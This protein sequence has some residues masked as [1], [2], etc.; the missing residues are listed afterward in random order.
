MARR[1]TLSFPGPFLG[2]NTQAMARNLAPAYCS[3]CDNVVFRD[4]HIETRPGMVEFCGEGDIVD[5]GL[6]SVKYVDDNTD[7]AIA[8]GSE[9]I[10][11]QAY[12]HDFQPGKWTPAILPSGYIP[13]SGAIARRKN[14]SYVATGDGVMAYR[15][16]MDN[17]VV[18]YAGMQPYTELDHDPTMADT[19]SGT[20][21]N[22]TVEFWVSRYNSDAD[23]ESNAVR[24]LTSGDSETLSMSNQEVTISLSNI[25]GLSYRTYATHVR[26]YQRRSDG[27]FGLFAEIPVDESSD[28]FSYS[29]GAAGEQNGG[30]TYS[31]AADDTNNI[32]GPP[33][34]NGVPPQNVQAMVY[35]DGRMFY[36]EGDKLWYS[37]SIDELQ[38]HPES[39][40]A[41]SY[42]TLRDDGVGLLVYRESLY[43]WTKRQVLRMSGFV[44][45]LTNAQVANGTLFDE[46]GFTAFVE[47]VEGVPGCISRDSIVEGDTGS[48][49][50]VFYAGPAN[51]YRFDGVNASPVSDN[52]VQNKH[53]EWVSADGVSSAHYHELNLVVFCYKNQG[54]LAY[55]YIR[56]TWTKWESLLDKYAVT[57]SVI[58]PMSTRSIHGTA[59]NDPYLML[60]NSGNGDLVYGGSVFDFTLYY[61]HGFSIPATWTGPEIDLGERVRRKRFDH[62]DVEIDTTGVT[63]GVVRAWVFVNGDTTKQIPAS[64]FGFTMDQADEGQFTH[65]LGFRGHSAQPKFR[66]DN[67]QKTRIIG[68]GL[69]ASLVGRR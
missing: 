2:L 18:E 59:P 62:L 54:I 20:G 25:A 57:S 13:G 19:G 10:Y 12:D 36:L 8:S 23:L 9:G 40:A 47:S 52:T 34:Q 21:I 55:D 66:L 69:N 27:Q 67:D 44:N 16:R 45:S 50:I 15:D 53:L 37:Q 7:Y 65:R 29:L 30:S 64:I 43:I 46:I 17:R 49:G 63:G 11:L 60:Q 42:L 4:G 56:R 68:Y 41:T 6:L 5:S 33:T 61:D 48:G 32:Y 14:D 3:D 31:I 51:L 39:I 38:G 35:H 58:G 26:V 1:A 28:S 22:G 24:C